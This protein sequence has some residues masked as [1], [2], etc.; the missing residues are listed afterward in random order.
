VGL[1]YGD[2]ATIDAGGRVTSPRG[3]V[4]RRGRPPRGDEFLPLLLEN[5][6]PAPSTVVRREALM[7]LL[8]IPSAF[9]FLDWYLTTGITERWNSCYVDAIVAD[10]R[11]HD[12]NMHRAMVVDGTGEIT[13]KQILDRLFTNG[14]RRDEKTRWRRQVYGSHY[15]VYA[16]K[17]FGSRL[18]ADARRCYS[19]AIMHQPRMLLEPG[20]LRRLAATIVGRRFYESA[21]GQVARRMQAYM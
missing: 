18:D 2:I 5:F 13:S 1:V 4:Q 6:I 8:P 16:D 11:V 19:A 9:R 10:Y 14:L 17:Y 21:K 7:P 15:R 3:M 20:V 12:G